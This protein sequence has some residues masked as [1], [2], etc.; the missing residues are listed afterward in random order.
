MNIIVHMPQTAE[1]NE[2][3]KKEA[4]KL[5]AELIIGEI[6]KRK[7]SLSQKERLLERVIGKLSTP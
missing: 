7:M 6:N 2:K 5:R 4:A 1:G 3:L